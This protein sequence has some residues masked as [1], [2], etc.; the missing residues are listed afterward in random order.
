MPNGPSSSTMK[1]EVC[2]YCPEHHDGPG[3]MTTSGAPSPSS[4]DLALPPCHSAS[5]NKGPESELGVGGTAH[6]A[7]YVMLDTKHHPL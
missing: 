6:P 7:P 5:P 4:A 3:S 2:H 1:V